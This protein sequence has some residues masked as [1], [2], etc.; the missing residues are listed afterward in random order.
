MP[1]SIRCSYHS[2]LVAAHLVVSAS[3]FTEDMEEPRCV[4]KAIV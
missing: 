4:M 2:H 1:V 3:V